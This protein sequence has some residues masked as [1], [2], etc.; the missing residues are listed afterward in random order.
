[1][2]AELI[3]DADILPLH[4]ADHPAVGSY[5]DALTHLQSKGKVCSVNL[6]EFDYKTCRRLGKTDG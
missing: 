4:F 6:A 5:F 3:L 1:M 2:N